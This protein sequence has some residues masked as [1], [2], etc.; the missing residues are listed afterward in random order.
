MWKEGD[1]LKI[2]GGKEGGIFFFGEKK[3]G[4]TP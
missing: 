1:E 2:R 4:S 3:E